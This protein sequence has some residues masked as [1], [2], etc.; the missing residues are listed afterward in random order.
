MRKSS[1]MKHLE[2]ILRYFEMNE[3]TQDGSTGGGRKGEGGNP[4]LLEHISISAFF[5]LIQ[6][7]VYS[8]QALKY[9]KGHVIK[10]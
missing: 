6:S 1:C 7:R 5:K 9:T 8:K 10:S 3:I 4:Q 2:R